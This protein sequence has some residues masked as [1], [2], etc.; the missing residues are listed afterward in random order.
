[1]NHNYTNNCMYIYIANEY[2]DVF[3]IS[4]QRFQVYRGQ[5]SQIWF[6]VQDRV[7]NTIVPTRCESFG[8]MITLHNS[9]DTGG[10][11]S[12]YGE[13]GT[14]IDLALRFIYIAHQ[15]PGAPF[16]PWI[17]FNPG[18]YTNYDMWN[19]NTYPFPNFNVCAVEFWE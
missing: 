3:A 12:I 4:Q 5:F 16:T 17:K 18:N 19:E 10:D 13:T 11:P 9:I 7:Y 1:M 8:D 2:K 6:H 14:L 15:K